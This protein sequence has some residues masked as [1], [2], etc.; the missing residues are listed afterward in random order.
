M[1]KI[2]DID[3]AFIETLQQ[4]P[5]F[6]NG[7]SSILFNN[8]TRGVAQNNFTSKN[9]A[10]TRVRKLISRD[11]IEYIIKNAVII[12]NAYYK[13]SPNEELN[14]VLE[15]SG[16]TY[17]KEE[18]FPNFASIEQAMPIITNSK[19]N[20]IIYYESNPNDLF[21]LADAVAQTR[22]N[23]TWYY[24]GGGVYKPDNMGIGT[25]FRYQL[26]TVDKSP[27]KEHLDK[28]THDVEV[29]EPVSKISINYENV[30][31]C[32]REVAMGTQVQ[33]SRNEYGLDGT[34]YATQDVGRRN[35]QEDSVIILTHPDNDQ[36]KFLAVADG[37]GGLSQGEQAS[38]YVIKEISEWFKRIPGDAYYFE[39]GLMEAYENELRRINDELY[40][41]YH[42]QAGSTFVGAIIT[43]YETLIASI[44]DSRA[45][46]IDKGNVSLL[47]RDES[48]AWNQMMA[49][50]NGNVTKE[51]I[52]DLRFA[53]EN[54]KITKCM[55][56]DELGVI[57]TI[58]IFNSS[59]DKLLLLSDGVTDLLSQDKISF[60]AQNTP[61]EQLTKALVDYAVNYNAQKRNAISGN[62]DTVRAG[63]D[64]ATAAM[65]VR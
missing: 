28:I 21:A 58:R 7:L 39:H 12:Y 62:F 11:F 8:A 41:R 36:F 50:K 48:L 34:L 20:T 37:M 59:Y 54:N 23:P 32:L 1:T 9:M 55:G 49:R 26:D 65:F 16:R 19:V 24:K 33:Y 3:V 18:L 13:I 30:N 22:F 29:V 25:E 43:E 60:I 52:D 27:V 64:N 4:H 42:R 38:N 44:G 47:T 57:Q 6:S 56:N 31:R 51:D 35:N 61:K 53:P 15:N 14:R 5:E 40:N 2:Q 63:K 10:R 45:Y 17:T 46:T